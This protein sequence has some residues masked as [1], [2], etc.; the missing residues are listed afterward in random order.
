MNASRLVI[1]PVHAQADSAWHSLL[2]AGQLQYASTLCERRRAR[3]IN[4]RIALRLTVAE[5]LQCDLHQVVIEQ[6]AT[7]RLRVCTEPPLFA[8][9]TYAQHLGLL[10]VGA[11]RL[12]LD[13]EDGVA[14]VFWRSAVR[15][16]MCDSERHWLQGRD[17]HTQEADFVWLWTRRESLLKYRGTGIRGDTRCLCRFYGAGPPHQ[18]SFNLAG[19]VG[20]FTGE[21]VTL[22]LTPSL[23]ALCGVW[24]FVPDFSWRKPPSE[25]V[26]CVRSE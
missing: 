18:H 8:S 16:Y 25:M 1:F 12:G 26:C 23:L 15:R 21:A 20:T 11:S 7:G 2:E 6:E 9:V 13:Y 10:V 14:P 4:A 3:Y 19:G 24:S 5:L 17:N 22:D